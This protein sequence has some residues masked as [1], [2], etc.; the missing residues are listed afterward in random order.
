M[1]HILFLCVANSARS[2]I[3]EALARRQAPD[4]VRV[5]SAGSAPSQVNPHALRVLAEVG[6]DASSQ[7]SKGIDAIPVAQVDTV[8]TLCAEEACPILPT[9]VRRLHWSLPDP[10]SEEGTVADRLRAFRSVRDEIARR[11]TDLFASQAPPS[12]SSDAAP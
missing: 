9:E 3:A 5:Y 2:Q 4:T 10:A 7:F 6:I 1:H 8:V 12:Q 11:L